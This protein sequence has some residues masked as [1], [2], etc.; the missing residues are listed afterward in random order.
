[1]GSYIISRLYQNEI[2]TWEFESS[3]CYLFDNEAS[4]K[5]IAVIHKVL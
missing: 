5:D 3:T 2:S 4:E 1:V